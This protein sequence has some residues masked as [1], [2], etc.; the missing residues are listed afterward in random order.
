M[1]VRRCVWALPLGLLPETADFPALPTSMQV[2]WTP[3]SA[4]FITFAVNG[5][6]VNSASSFTNA[7]LCT[8]AS[9]QHW[10][11]HLMLHQHLYIANYAITIFTNYQ[12]IWNFELRKLDNMALNWLT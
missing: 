10:T 4:R 2:V 11:N 1:L 6:N 8:S 7:T 12:K 5:G 3:P 9:Y